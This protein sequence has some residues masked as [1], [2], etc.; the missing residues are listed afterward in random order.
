MN[1]VRDD[2]DGSMGIIKMLIPPFKGMS[3]TEAYPQWEK[4]VELIFDCH[5]YFEEKKEK[6]IVLEFTSYVITWWDHVVTS[7]RMNRERP[8]NTWDNLKATMQKR[9]VP[10]H[11]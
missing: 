11:Y 1:F 3:D 7:R 6:I 2:V 4:K 5:N 9:F 10:S 8:I